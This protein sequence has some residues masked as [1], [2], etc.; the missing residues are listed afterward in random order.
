MMV[1]YVKKHIVRK[2]PR[3]RSRLFARTQAIGKKTEKKPVVPPRQ[4]IA[5]DRKEIRQPT[6][7]RSYPIAY[8]LPRT[9]KIVGVLLQALISLSVRTI[10]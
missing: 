3:R 4:A 7:R 8:R 5:R 1:W 2:K 9:S 10:C 6:R